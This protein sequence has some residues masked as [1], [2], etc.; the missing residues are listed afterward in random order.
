MRQ[1]STSDGKFHWVQPTPGVHDFELRGEDGELAGRLEWE[2]ESGSLAT[3]EASDGKWS[4]KRLGFLHPHVTVRAPG[5][6]TNLARF[7]ASLSGGG[8]LRFAEGREY[9]WL[10]NFWL[11]EWSW[12]DAAGN[13]IL[14]FRR[15]F[16]TERREGSVE[17]HSDGE[18]IPHLSILVIVGW[19]LIILMA[20]DAARA[21]VP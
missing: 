14:I 21:I 1:I 18:P 8:V 13:H 15:N 12:V 4:L 3:A 11:S 6:E 20:E 10:S 5:H 16:S 2:K 7:D 19:Y 17:I 9:R